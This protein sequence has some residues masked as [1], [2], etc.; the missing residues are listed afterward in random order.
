MSWNIEYK[1]TQRHELAIKIN[2][3]RQLV[4]AFRCGKESVRFQFSPRLASPLWWKIT[5]T[6]YSPVDRSGPP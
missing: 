3:N 2:I 6:E 5:L 4:T 1:L